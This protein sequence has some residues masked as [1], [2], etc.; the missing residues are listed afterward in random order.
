MEH[1]EK[2]LELVC[3]CPCHS[4]SNMVVMGEQALKCLGRL[5]LLAFKR[6]FWY[7]EYPLSTSKSVMHCAGI[8]PYLGWREID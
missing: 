2:N 7:F 3:P 4:W 8:K 1:F 6:A 5:R